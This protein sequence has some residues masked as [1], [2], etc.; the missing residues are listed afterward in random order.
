M[1]M[2]E[3]SQHQHKLERGNELRFEVGSEEVDIEL[4]KD[5]AEM[6]GVPLKNFTKY[7]FPPGFRGAIY[8]HTKAEIE[9]TGNLE[10]E[11]IAPENKPMLSYVNVH[12]ALKEIRDTITPDSNETGPIVMVTGPKHVGKSTLCK[13]LC[14]YAVR[15]VTPVIFVDLDVGQNCV[16]PTCISMI[17]VEQLTDLVNGF[18]TTTP[19]AY[20]YGHFD[21]LVN[22]KLYDLMLENMSEVFKKKLKTTR[23]RKGGAVIDTTAWNKGKYYD[24]VVKAAELFNVTHVV[25]LDHERMYS[26]LGNDLPNT[27]KIIHMQKSGGVEALSPLQEGTARK[28]T[29]HRYFY[30]TMNMNYRPQAYEFSYD[31][32]R[33]KLELRVAR[34]GVEALPSSLLPYGMSEEHQTRTEYVNYTSELNNRIVALIRDVSSLSSSIIKHHVVGFVLIKN[35]N[36]ESKTVEVLLPAYPPIASRL[37]VLTEVLFT[38]DILHRI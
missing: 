25:V 2:V 3:R 10:V 14:N 17:P 29:V 24:S 9:I 34:I 21:P 31:C 18:D 13:I 28:Y 26:D 27:I 1:P 33:E 4:T 5:R 12:A 38:D 22:Q 16:M 8:T 15:D 35:V 36:T 30:G 6:F 23:F 32:P 37:G 20:P 11:Y 19:F 7:A